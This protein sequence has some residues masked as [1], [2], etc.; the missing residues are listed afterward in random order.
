VQRGFGGEGEARPRPHGDAVAA[1]ILDQISDANGPPPGAQLYV[2]D[3]FSPGPQSG[4]AASLVSGLSWLTTSG[5]AVINVSLTG[6]PNPV[7]AKV[8]ESVVARGVVVVAAA[9]NDGPAAPPAFPAAY[10]QVVAVTAV[11]AARR[12]YR[13]ANR[14]AYVMFAALGVDL[15]AAGPG[16]TSQTVSGTSFASPT[17]AVELARRLPLADAEVAHRALAA[18]TAE[19]VDLGAPGRDP[20]FGIG[21]IEPR[22]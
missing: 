1:L 8:I 15:K 21:L 3:I 18:V 12:P 16:G 10:P 7:V 17:V 13:Y 5:A 6:P 11:D 2:A 20:V 4:S 9:G 19:A 14:G 22:P